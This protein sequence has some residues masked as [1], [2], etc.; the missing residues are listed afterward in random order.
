MGDCVTQTKMKVLLVVCLLV[1]A[2]LA[3]TP[4]HPHWPDQFSATL[5]THEGEN[6]NKG[7][8]VRWFYS[9]P[10]KMERF[11]GPR[12]HEGE[13]VWA[14]IIA[15]HAAGVEWRLHY[16]H[17]PDRLSC[18]KRNTTGP[19]NRPDFSKFEY[20]G[21]ASVS[22]ELAYHWRLHDF[23]DEI[24]MDFFNRE[25]DGEPARFDFRD[26]RRGRAEIFDF[27]EMDE[28]PQDHSM[29]EIPAW[30]KADCN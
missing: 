19:M 18:E 11:D 25:R 9:Y 6:F 28:G 17:N 21:Q 27:Y 30:L 10:A 26:L 15:D 2:A 1:A 14:E 5:V 23:K 8:F 4:P 22:F 24:L 3:A 29:F 12:F 20:M 16:H 13:I 7:D